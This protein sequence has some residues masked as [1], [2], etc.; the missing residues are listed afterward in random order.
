MTIFLLEEYNKHL[1]IASTSKRSNKKLR[2]LPEV[3]GGGKDIKQISETVAVTF[4]PI[5]EVRPPIHI[6]CIYNQT[7][8]NHISKHKD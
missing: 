3:R 4:V 8:L 2:Y 6:W 7:R 5:S 1:Y